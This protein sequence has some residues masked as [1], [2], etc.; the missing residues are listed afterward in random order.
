M[1]AKFGN[2]VQ[3]IVTEIVSSVVPKLSQINSH[4]SYGDNQSTYEHE[5]VAYTTQ[6]R[7]KR[8]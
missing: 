1:N 8:N 4:H 7:A 6:L 3:V 2:P 5:R